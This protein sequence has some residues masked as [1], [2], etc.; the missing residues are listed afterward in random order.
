MRQNG[1]EMLG[2]VF[3]SLITALSVADDGRTS[4]GSLLAD[5]VIVV[6]IILVCLHVGRIG[7]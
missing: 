6:V 3:A 7:T 5:L 2:V 4:I 1:V